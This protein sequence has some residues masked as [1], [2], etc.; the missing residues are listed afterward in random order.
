VSLATFSQKNISTPTHRKFLFSYKYISKL[1][2][3]SNLLY[4]L[5]IRFSLEKVKSQLINNQIAAQQTVI[6]LF[7]S[8]PSSPIP[9]APHLPSNANLQCVRAAN[10]PRYKKGK[11]FGR[12]K[13]QKRGKAK[14]CLILHSYFLYLPRIRR[15]SSLL[16]NTFASLL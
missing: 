8:F 10:Q 7:S 12:V 6:D 9:I 1:L 5:T 15:A 3:Q 4:L 11:S 13:L 16:N 14:P 2:R